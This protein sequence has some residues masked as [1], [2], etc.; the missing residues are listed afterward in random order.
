MT[1]KHLVEGCID[2]NINAQK[3]L[4]ELYAKKMLS[5]CIRYVC[6][7]DD[8]RDLLHDGF[9][10]VF[11]KIV[12][13]QGTGS[14]EGW[15][16]RLFVNIC[17]EKLRKSKKDLQQ[18][19]DNYSEN[20]EMI[21]NSIVDI[22]EKMDADRLL[23]Y[24]KELPEQ[25]RSTFNLFAVEGYSHDEISEMLGIA[26]ATSRSNYFRA[27]MLLQKRIEKDIYKTK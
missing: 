13:Y 16:R 6:D 23:S 14:F 1:E 26:S 19:I 17:L 20:V 15:I 9:I 5:V 12:D 25:F 2:K 27:R 18:S 11:D 22:G 3:Q 4:Y 24:I 10:R 7:E 8:A 21:D